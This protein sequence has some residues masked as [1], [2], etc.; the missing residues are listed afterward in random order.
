M[1]GGFK[2]CTTTSS[3]TLFVMPLPLFHK[4]KVNYSNAILNHG[5]NSTMQVQVS[6]DSLDYLCS[7]VWNGLNVR[8]VYGSLWGRSTIIYFI[9]YLTAMS[10]AQT[11]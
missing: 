11:T 8:M 3:D 6:E 9:V 10:V 7:T 2:W 5:L 4:V 1:L